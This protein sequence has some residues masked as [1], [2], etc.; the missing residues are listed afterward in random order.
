[1]IID[2]HVHIVAPDEQRYPR[3]LVPGSSDW[4][5]DMSGET[6]LDL[7]G[8]AGI[9]RALLVQA[10]TAY[11]YDNSY[12]ADVAALQPERFVSV[13]IVDA[14]RPDAPDQLTYW[15]K[16]RGVRGLRLFAAAQAE[17]PWLDDPHSFPLWERAAQLDIPLCACL[18]RFGQLKQLVTA[19]ARYPQVR[20][21]LDH[22]GAP[23]L[24][25]GPPFDSAAPLFELVKFPNVFLK[26]S[27]VNLY[28]A[29][30]GRSTPK[31][32][33]RRLLEV[34]GAQRLMWGSN[35]PNT[36]D[37]SLHDQLSL[38]LDELSFASEA[39]RRW[40]FGDTARSL[41]PSPG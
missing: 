34:F 2:T 15:V 5:L 7:M 41:W 22:L 26:F 18:R 14:T 4:V 29:A 36:Y 16:E 6:M 33:F 10:Y 12:V 25:D 35:F 40:I 39:E 27:S 38:A 9:D 21:A 24:D 19:I 30:Q 23:R 1:M 28:A 8:K 31:D 17:A 11:Q 32:F 20:V 13:C 3:Q 37:R